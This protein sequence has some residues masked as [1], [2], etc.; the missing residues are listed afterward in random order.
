MNK[1]TICIIGPGIVGQATGKVF[2]AK[3]YEVAFLGGNIEK[4]KKLR[5]EGY[6]AYER[7]EL[8]DS[9]YNFDISMLTVPTPTKEGKINLQA[10]ESAATDLGKRLKNTKKY[11]L[12]VVKSTVPPGTTQ[13]LVIPLIEKY[14]GKKAGKDF[15]ACMNPEY[16]R[17]E[18]AYDDT[19]NPW[20][21]LIGEYDQKSGD[22]L[23]SVYKNK[24]TCPQHR[25]KL[26]EAE[27]QKYVHN[28]F[29][30]A[31]IS[32][33]NEMR[34]IAAK[35]DVDA[36][37]IFKYTAISCEG[38]WNPKYGIRNMGPFQGSC[39]PK[40]TQA[41]YYWATTHGFDASLLKMVIDVN[42]KFVTALGLHEFAFEQ[43][44][45]L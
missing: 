24:F 27:M 31:K 23:E 42:N 36:D 43:K 21:I 34:E 17:E 10:L 32:F 2:A 39:L 3:G 33:Y 29:N 16:L 11:H 41:F 38:M 45:I 37:K 30:A 25:C 12:V 6:K 5:G 19:L 9:G 20:I 14:S 40:D 4:V 13:N 22:L 7:H 28:L 15:G 8:M 35:I 44:N 1:P 26:M 18:T